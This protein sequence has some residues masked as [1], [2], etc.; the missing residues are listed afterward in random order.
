MSDCYTGTIMQQ[1]QQGIRQRPIFL[2]H[3]KLSITVNLFQRNSTVFGIWFFFSHFVRRRGDIMS[4]VVLTPEARNHKEIYLI[5]WKRDIWLK[6]VSVARESSI[7]WC[8]VGEV[9]MRH[10]QHIQYAYHSHSLTLPL[11]SFRPLIPRLKLCG[12]S[13][14]YVMAGASAV[15]EYI[16]MV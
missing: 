13:L 3:K 12:Q 2:L 16:R 14:E 11:L 6:F 9:P 8:S 15:K 5:C 1:I 10:R 7:L 4:K